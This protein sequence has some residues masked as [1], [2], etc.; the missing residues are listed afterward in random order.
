MPQL[1]SVKQRSH[2]RKKRRTFCGLKSTAPPALQLEA[3]PED[4]E[5]VTTDSSLH[6]SESYMNTSSPSRKVVAIN[7]S[8]TVKKKTLTG[9]R[10]IDIADLVWYF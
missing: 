2:Y 9:Y 4:N 7:I 5:N 8:T 3:V 1:R 6:V 10:M